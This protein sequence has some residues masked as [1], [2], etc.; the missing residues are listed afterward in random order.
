MNLQDIYSNMT[1]KRMDDPQ[2][3]FSWIRNGARLQYFR[4]KN[5]PDK[6]IPPSMRYLNEIMFK[7]F[8][9]TMNNPGNSAYVNLFAPTEILHAFGI[10]P[11][12]VESVATFLS[13]LHLEDI[14]VEEAEKLGISETLCSYHKTFIGAVEKELLPP[15]AFSVASSIICDANTKTFSHIDEKYGIPGFIVDVPGVCDS[16]SMDYVMAQLSEMIAFIESTTGKK[17]DMGKLSEI[18]KIE[19]ETKKNMAKYME[20]VSK[21]NFVNHVTL[22]MS[23]L[24]LTHSGMGKNETN[25]YFAKLIR[26]MDEYISDEAI[27]IF[28]IHIM[29]YFDKTI[30][31]YFNYN[32]KYFLIGMDLN[33]YDMTPLNEEKPLESIAYKMLNN[34]YNGDFSKRVNR[35]EELIEILKPDGVIN[36]LQWGCKQTI[37][38]AGLVKEMAVRNGIP[39]LAFDGDGGDRRNN[40]K[41][42]VKTRLEAFFEIIKERKA[43]LK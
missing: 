31:E 23:K 7:F 17:L 6:S 3:A 5:F 33:Y 42:Q 22:E 18:I 25:E 20:I 41:G 21:K 40:P 27:R 26:D 37:G 4:W 36:F 1:R 28:W 34:I 10:N 13:G 11:M 32:R 35:F 43:I 24:M 9:D 12:F 15:P 29:P 2:K 30:R 8:R 38:G 39:Y 19:N 14:L 16:Y